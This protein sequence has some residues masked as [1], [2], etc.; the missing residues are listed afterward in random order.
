M[1]LLLTPWGLAALGANLGPSFTVSIAATADVLTATVTTLSA[2]GT[3]AYAYDW[4]RGGVSLG[5]AD[6]ATYDTTGT[7]G[8][9][10]VRVTGTDDVGS[11]AVTSNAIEIG[12][13]LSGGFSNGF[14]SGFDVSGSLPGG[15]SNGFSNGFE[16]AA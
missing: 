16:V 9:Y 11:R 15:F 14:S 7:P 3:P 12:A 4:R 8:V 2:T 1:H 10:T 6:A 5:A 13:A